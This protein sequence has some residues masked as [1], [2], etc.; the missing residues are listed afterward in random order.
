M[1]KSL[2]LFL[3]V[4]IIAITLCSCSFI[5]DKD[6]LASYQYTD[7]EGN[8]HEYQTDDKGKVVTEKGGDKKETTTSSADPSAEGLTVLVTDANGEPVTDKNGNAVTSQVNVEDLVNSLTSTTTTTKK[9]GKTTTTKKGQTTTT[10][11]PYN[12][13]EDDLLDEGSKINKT[14][15]KGTV[16]D[17]IVKTKTYTLDTV[18]K[19]TEMDMPTVFTFKGDDF[20]ASIALNL[21]DA[22]NIE[23][24][25]LS[26]DKKY[27]MVLPTLG[28]YG[29]LDKETFGE[30]SSAS[31]SLTNTASY[32]KSTKVKS[33]STTYTCEEYKTKEGV[34]IKYYF[35]EKNEWKR[36]EVIDK[37]DVSVFEIKSFTKGAKE[38]LFKI[39]SVYKKV[40]LSEFL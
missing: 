24:R 28:M 34:V 20:A 26:K 23:A 10:T 27:Y 17:P 30:F 32:V 19:T 6:A 31:S 11:S 15:L 5:K 22:L 18:V 21:S 36:W 7:T 33:G 38:S 4:A 8:T 25:V 14:N 35:N 40:D 12:S 2:S 39:S 1:K 29:E 13:S 3:S 16:I 9:G 37:D